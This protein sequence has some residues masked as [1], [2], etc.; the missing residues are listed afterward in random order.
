MVS[1]F[2]YL[3]LLTILIIAL[4][5]CGATPTAQQRPASTVAPT[6]TPTG[7]PTAALASPVAT[8]EEA[9]SVTDD[10]G[11]T[12]T[13][14]AVPQRIVSLAPS[15]TEIL[16]AV[17]AGSQVVGVTQFCNYPPEADALPEIGGF[18]VKSL[19]VET[20]IG[21]E[22]D[23]VIAGTASQKAVAEQ[24]EPL[25]IPVVVLAPDSFDGVYANI[26]Q[27]GTLT[28]R[29]AGAEQVVAA[30]RMRVAAITERVASIP[31]A[32]RPTVYW[33][34]FNDPL[35]TTGPRTFIGQMIEL[36]GATNI[37]ADASE[38]YPQISAEAIFERDPQVIL[39]PDNQDELL[40]VEGVGKRPGWADIQAVR[41]GRVYTLNRDIVSR[42]G[43]RLADALA[44]LATVLY[45]ELFATAPVPTNGFPLTVENCGVTQ[46]YAKPPERVVTMNQ[47]V[48]EVMLAL[49]LHE[50]L[51]GTAYL[52]DAI[53]PEFQA[54][55]AAIPVLS[56]VYPALEVL[57][58]A[59]PDF[60]YSGFASAFSDESGRTRAMLAENGANSF[61]STEYCAEG[62]VTMETV[63]GDIR[64]IAAI[65][66]VPERAEAL[67]GEMQAQ[68]DAVTAQLPAGVPLR[69]FVY[70]SGQD[71][72]FTAGGNG[73]VNEIIKL[74]G[75]QN[76]F[77]DLADAFG[78]PS[79]EEV[80]AR[81]PEVILILDYGDTTAEQKRAFL[82][83]NPALAGID[84]IKNKRFAV[85]PLS[86]V[87]AGVRNSNA[88]EK[89]ALAL[90]QKALQ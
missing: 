49:G 65:F 22:P 72:P 13:R 5:A 54:A 62:P 66:G 64:T 35:T 68:I 87:V 31:A 61:L 1:R 86:G 80:I 9:I 59:E 42:P 39:G 60:V 56:D 41:D 34:A 10:L 19:S 2:R 11:R 23:L 79:W 74:A 38:S 12:I 70:D 81:D 43:P 25:D 67:V 69:V 88:V 14:N 58:A 73:I 8:K 32:E 3:G 7:I 18:S 52:D 24:L 20:I 4:S 89:L 15:V 29:S 21:L 77:A 36:V 53:L 84:A 44:A 48:T 30:T 37:F 17:G 27:I 76:S 85:L 46:T 51:V 16:F 82:L 47:H 55:Y 71:K 33:E 90:Y 45:P 57:L 26:L 40:T 6:L 83:G 63:Y 75:G 28:G 78:E 50:R